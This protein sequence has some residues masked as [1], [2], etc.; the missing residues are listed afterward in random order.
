MKP[1]LRAAEGLATQ[2]LARRAALLALPD[3]DVGRMF[4]GA[5]D[6]LPGLIVERLGPALV[7]QWHEGH[8]VADEA[9]VQAVCAYLAEQLGTQA[10]YRK[11]FPK[12]RT[13]NRPELDRAHRDP[14]PWLG[15]PVERELCVREHGLRFLVCPYDG[16][17]TGIFL[18]HRAQ[19][20]RV[21]SAADGRRVLNTFAYTCGFTV[22]AAVGG[23]TRTASVD[24]SRRYLEWG[25]RNLAVNDLALDGHWFY[26]SDVLDFYRRAA[27]QQQAFEL[28]LLD[29][30]TFARVGGGRNVFRVEVDLP[31]LVAG[32]L[33]LLT[34]GGLVL[35]SVN[36]RGLSWRRLEAIVGQAADT[37]GRML[38][39]AERLALPPDFVG[40]DA[41]ARALWFEV[42]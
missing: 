27:R 20:L 26:C 4:N 12:D 2:A 19:R 7:A 5:A 11:H 33:P 36:Y 32:A 30:P 9:A 42:A 17:A 15:M 25:K 18:D 10:V 31:R 38:V 39:S 22:A 8:V 21:R 14:Q 13:A 41:S 28:I 29:P 34:P 6:G 1:D 23:A 40:D 35:L 24:V 3:T 37:Q 16:Y